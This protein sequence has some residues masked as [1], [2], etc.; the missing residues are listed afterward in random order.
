MNTSSYCCFIFPLVSPQT[1]SE[2]NKQELLRLRQ[3]QWVPVDW[4]H[5]FIPSINQA[6]G[7]LQNQA[8]HESIP[9]SSGVKRSLYSRGV[10]RCFCVLPF[11][12]LNKPAQ[13]LLSLHFSFCF[14]AH[15]IHFLLMS[16]RCEG[17][18]CFSG[19]ALMK[20]FIPTHLSTAGTC[21]SL[22]ARRFNPS[23]SRPP[24]RANPIKFGLC[25]REEDNFLSAGSWLSHHV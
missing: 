2:P 19:S 10:C 16:Q 14:T 25:W 7:D 17:S 6:H 12:R 3:Q 20:W 9:E 18:R 1:A 15:K 11:V 22:C 5:F 24:R 21:H 23:S 13:K 4:I 8:G